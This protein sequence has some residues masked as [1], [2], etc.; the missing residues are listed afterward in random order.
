MDLV[1]S[2]V[3]TLVSPRVFSSLDS[4]LDRLLLLLLVVVSLVDGVPLV[5]MDHQSNTDGIPVR[6]TA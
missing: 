5:R 6:R 2:R 3:S 1:E 4:S